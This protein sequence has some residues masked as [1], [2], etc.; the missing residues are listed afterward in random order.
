MKSEK[1]SEKKVKNHEVHNKNNV[2]LILAHHLLLQDSRESIASFYSDAGGVNYGKVPVT[3]EI[4]FGI[5][6]NYR[7]GTLEIAIRQ[8]KELAPADPK[9]H[10]SDPYVLIVVNEPKSCLGKLY[11]LIHI[12]ALDRIILFPTS[13]LYVRA[14][15]LSQH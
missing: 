10:R 9:R 2:A 12:Y 13:V 1:F 15:F 4:Q 14:D 6:Y 5:D 8:C 3:G 7:T 11:K